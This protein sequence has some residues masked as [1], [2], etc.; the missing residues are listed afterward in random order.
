MWL[1][2]A[3]HPWVPFSQERAPSLKRERQKRQAGAAQFVLCLPSPILAS[4]CPS[5]STLS[6]SEAPKTPASWPR[7]CLS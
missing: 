1:R 4:F 3:A 2:P 5:A 6:L 7:L